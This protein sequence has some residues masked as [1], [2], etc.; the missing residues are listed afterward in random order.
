M[1]KK[2]LIMFIVAHVGFVLQLIIVSLFH[3][4]EFGFV[5]GLALAIFGVVVAI[6]IVLYSKVKKEIS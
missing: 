4:S 3:A 1:K 5:Y 6:E 2:I